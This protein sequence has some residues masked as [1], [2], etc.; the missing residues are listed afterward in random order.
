MIFYETNF[1]IRLPH[2][3]N[4]EEQNNCIFILSLFLI[5]CSLNKVWLNK[6]WHFF[7]AL[8]SPHQ[9][10]TLFQVIQP[11]VGRCPVRAESSTNWRTASWATTPREGQG[12][13]LPASGYA[14]CALHPNLPTAGE[15]LWPGGPPSEETSHSGDSGCCDRE[16]VRAEEWNGGKRVFRVSLHGWCPSRLEA[17]TC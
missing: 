12:S 1:P 15:D 2:Q 13:V 17:H 8:P 4:T 7:P 16:G 11:A 6:L 3:K 14:L 5:N 9:I 10:F